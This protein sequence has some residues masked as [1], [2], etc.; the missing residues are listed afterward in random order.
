M[1]ERFKGIETLSSVINNLNVNFYKRDTNPEISFSDAVDLAKYATTGEGASLPSFIKKTMI[2]S[3]VYIERSCFDDEI[4]SDVLQCAQ[5]LYISWILTAVSLNGC[6]AGSKTLVKDAVNVIASEDFTKPLNRYY[7]DTKDIVKGIENFGVFSSNPNIRKNKELNL[8]KFDAT[9]DRIVEIEEELSE[10]RK[11]NRNNNPNVTDDIIRLRKELENL[12]QQQRREERERIQRKKE[13]ERQRIK[14][15]QQQ[16]QEELRRQKE[17]DSKKLKI[18]TGASVK[19]PISESKLPIGRI[20]ELSLASPNGEKQKL[21]VMVNLYPQFLP[22]EIVHE[23]FKLNRIETLGERWLKKRTGEISF[24][25]DFVFE[26]DKAREEAKAL[27]KDPSGLLREIK[28]REHSKLFKWLDNVLGAGYS[29]YSNKGKLD[30]NL[31]RN[32]ANGILILNKNDFNRWCKE[33]NL[34]FNMEN[35][36]NKFM[37][38]GMFMMVIVLDPDFQTVD[39]YYHGIK[40]KSEFSYKQISGQAKSEKYDLL[41]LMKAFNNVNAPKF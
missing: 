20:V 19:E 12:R 33:V 11:A 14:Q 28:N 31:S 7:I 1:N 40:Y 22:D 32:I 3:S 2:A 25:K 23:L 39:M 27:K 21:N 6:L 9:S 26:L 36:R 37:F 35:D 5:Q 4:L 24:W 8:S 17:E 16:Q 30:K 34:N 29:L 15:E 13:E 38:K 10:L 41:S 18:P